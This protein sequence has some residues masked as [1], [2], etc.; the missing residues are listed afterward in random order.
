MTW[1][2]PVAFCD[3]SHTKIYAIIYCEVA[4]LGSENTDDTPLCITEPVVAN[5]GLPSLLFVM[6]TSLRSV[7]YVV[8]AC[9]GLAHIGR[10]LIA[11]PA[12][13]PNSRHPVSSDPHRW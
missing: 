6:H 9:G 11:P 8:A 1:A 3:V 5:M 7:V 10:F 12:L 4:L 2:Y 13:Q